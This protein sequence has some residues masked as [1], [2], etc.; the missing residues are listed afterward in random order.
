MIV[1]MKNNKQDF[2]VF[3]TVLIIMALM[4]V[5]AGVYVYVTKTIKPKSATTTNQDT[6]RL[7][8]I[9]V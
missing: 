8:A 4:L 5:G 1:S 3:S 2:A 6:I 7:R 9:C